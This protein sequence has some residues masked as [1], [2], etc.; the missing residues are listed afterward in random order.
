M[1][2]TDFLFVFVAAAVA[3]TLLWKPLRARLR[4]RQ[5]AR[6]VGL[7]RHKREMLEAKFFDIASTLGKPRDLRWL[8]C[9]WQTPVTFGRDRKTGL[10]TAFV[11]V[12]IRFEA[13]EGGDMEGVAAVDTVRDASALFHYRAGCWG[14]GGR[15]FFNLD[16]NEAL[17]RLE[18]QYEAVPTPVPPKLGKRSSNLPGIAE[19]PRDG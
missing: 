11:A 17:L 8:E 3:L 6:A 12:N 19:L 2:W 15:A 18:D 16:P 4:A 7:F 9:N 5:D 13:V 1:G 10:L 14:T